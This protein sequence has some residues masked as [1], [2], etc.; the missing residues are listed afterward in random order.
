MTYPYTALGNCD[1]ARSLMLVGDWIGFTGNFYFEISFTNGATDTML[2]GLPFY[3]VTVD[4]ADMRQELDGSPYDEGFSYVIPGN[5]FQ[6]YIKVT[7]YWNTSTDVE[8]YTLK[9]RKVY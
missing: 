4:S 3:T 9:L 5:M 2:T 8:N 7:T 6:G 1:G